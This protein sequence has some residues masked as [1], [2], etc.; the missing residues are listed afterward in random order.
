MAEC[1]SVERDFEKLRQSEERYHALFNAIDEGFCI[2]EMLFDD[3]NRPVDYRFIEVNPAFER[4]SGLKDAQGRTVREMVPQ[5]ED[6]WFQI[7]GQVALSGVPVRFVNRAEGLHRWFDVYA[8][9]IGEPEGRRVAVLFNDI[10]ERRRSEEALRESTQQLRLIFE[11]ATEYAIVVSDCDRRVTGWNSGAQRLLGYTEAEILGQSADI[12]FTPEDRDARAPAQEVSLAVENGRAVNERWHVRKDGTRFWGS[13]LMFPLRDREEDLSGFLKIMRDQTA[14]RRAEEVLRQSEERLRIAVAT[15]ELGTWAYNPTSGEIHADERARAIFGIPADA[16]ATYEIFLAAIHPGD[17]QRVHELLQRVLH[18]HDG[19]SYHD[20]YRATGPD[21]QFERWIR[22]AGRVYFDESHRPVQFVGTVL[23]ISDLVKARE[24]LARRGEELELIV[25]ERTTQLRDTVQQLET[26]SYSVVHDMR[27]PLRSV[28]SFANVLSEEYGANL[29]EKARSYLHRIKVS[30]ERMDA[31]IT[32]VLTYSRVTST[33]A[34]LTPVDLDTLVH[35]IAEQYPQFQ[36][37]PGSVHIHSPLPVVQGNRALLTQ[38][39]SNLMGNALK[40]VPRDRKPHVIIRA[41]SRQ[42]RVRLW[43]EDNG[44]GIE[45]EYRNRIFGLFQR[46]HRADQYP[47]T[48]VGLAIVQKAVER[49]RGAVGFESQ[50]QQG[51]R[52]WIELPAPQ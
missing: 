45:P 51:S 25:A 43:F 50:P 30:V 16:T 18:C 5:H 9:R 47:G 49:M 37:S 20:E 17:R 48:G 28:R 10:T 31:L 21:N 42:A 36:E 40:F 13:G 3:A 24:V 39:I 22:G 7:Y 41:E 12:L 15:A 26:F 1:G 14:E 32:D 19:G 29:D 33:E 46:L 35:E 4:H 27:A 23:D 2:V 11:S 52:F 34:S 6:H 8:F 44:I 38:C